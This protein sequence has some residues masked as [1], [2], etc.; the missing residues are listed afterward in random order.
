MKRLRG[1]GFG[2]VLAL[3]LTACHGAGPGAADAALMQTDG[4]FAALSS[5]KGFAAAFQQYATDNAVFLPENSAPLTGKS[6]IAQ[7]LAGIPDGTRLDWTPQRAEVSVS[8]ELGYS[9]GIYTLSGTNSTGQ[10]TVAYGKYLSVWK[11]QSGEWKLAVMMTNQSP[12]PA[13]G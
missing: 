3:L 6:A 9:W 5:Q 10:A 4:A 11:K 1:C 13:G 12:G 8:G 2:L 7:S